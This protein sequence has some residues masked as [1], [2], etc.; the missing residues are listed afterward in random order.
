VRVS[1]RKQNDPISSSFFASLRN[2]VQLITSV[3]TVKPYKREE[4]R[5]PWLHTF[6]LPSIIKVCSFYALFFI[7]CFME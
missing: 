3:K 6:S 5:K 1:A 7:E 4:A 2:T